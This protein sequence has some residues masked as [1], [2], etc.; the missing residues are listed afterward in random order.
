MEGECN[1]RKEGGTSDTRGVTV[2]KNGRIS[3]LKSEAGDTSKEC[4]VPK[5]TAKVVRRRV[6]DRRRG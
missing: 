5:E 2:E 4:K 3:Q 1:S 6:V